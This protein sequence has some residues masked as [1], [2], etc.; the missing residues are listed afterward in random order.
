MKNEGKILAD[1]YNKHAKKL[2]PDF[3]FDKSHT[4][5]FQDHIW[6]I[7][8]YLNENVNA[9]NIVV[10]SDEMS[11]IDYPICYDSGKIAF[12]DPDT[13]PERI[14]HIVR[15]FYPEIRYPDKFAIH[16]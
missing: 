15:S 4:I 8:I 9:D 16:E 7:E 14:K 12:C 1:F 11:I 5:L 10:V 6:S 2:E 13:I 3:W